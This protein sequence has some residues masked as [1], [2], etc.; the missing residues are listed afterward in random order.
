MP[1][2]IKTIFFG[3]DDFAKIILSKL[4]DSEEFFIDLVITKPDKKIGRSQSKQENPVKELAQKQKLAI[5]QPENL[6]HLQLAGDIDLGVTAQ[7]GKII[8]KQLLNAPEH[9]IL[10]IHTSLL[11]K[12]RGPAPIQTALL[13]GENETGV[14]IMKMDEGLDTGPIIFQKTQEISSTD[15]YP[16]L[17]EKLA[18]LGAEALLESAPK[19]VEGELE[20][21]QQDDKNA[22]STSKF[23]REDGKIDWQ[24]SAENIYNKY[25][26]FTPWPG[27]WTEWN[28]DRFKLHEITPEDQQIQPGKVKIAGKKMFIGCGKNSISVQKIQPSGKQKMDIVDFINGYGDRIHEEV[29]S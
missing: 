20:P 2:K 23:D 26:A 25:R 19:Y 17:N 5:K 28:G 24:N 18:Q 9:G 1:D 22:T 3:T 7:F 12:Y 21:R 10:N 29:L 15:K 11:P 14:T 16:D 4:I 6:N 13:E 8:P 27:I